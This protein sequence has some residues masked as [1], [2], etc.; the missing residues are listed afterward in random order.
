VPP[1]LVLFGQ[2]DALVPPQDAR[3]FEQVPGATVVMM[4]GAGHSPMV[5][6]PAQTLQLIDRFLA[7]TDGNR[8]DSP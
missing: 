5:E 7:S 2:L 6:K 3:L 8:D 4:D 1:L